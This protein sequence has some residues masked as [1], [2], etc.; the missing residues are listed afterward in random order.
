[1]AFPANSVEKIYRNC[2]NEIKDFFK[3]RHNGKYLV[4]NLCIERPYSKD[5]FDNYCYIPFH[6]HNSPSIKD[7][8][9]LCEV[10]KK[11]LD[12]DKE[13]VIAIHCKAGKSR[14]GLMV[15]CLLMY[16]G[17]FDKLSDFTI[18]YYNELRTING[19]GINIPSQLRYVK[20]WESFLG[21]N[22]SAD[23]MPNYEFYLKSVIV[24]IEMIKKI[25]QRTR[26]F[27]SI[28]T[29]NNLD[30][31]KNS[32]NN[33]EKFDTNK[34]KLYINVEMNTYYKKEVLD[35]LTFQ[36]FTINEI[37]IEGIQHIEILFEY[38][39]LSPQ[40]TLFNDIK[41]ELRHSEIFHNKIIGA[42]WLN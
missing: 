30:S 27:Q 11:F 28:F 25:A 18:L 15:C 37:Y 12:N 31:D 1:M 33:I 34:L 24:P 35:T 29:N 14:T 10:A 3:K 26:K 23:D 19:V 13:N 17:Y 36:N 6:D 16:L 20:Y 39:E 41:I 4:F 38:P 9:N 22:L 32:Q 2:V 5:T 8:Q 21:S 42:A 7:I 40:Y